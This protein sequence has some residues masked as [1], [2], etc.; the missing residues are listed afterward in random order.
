MKNE[1]ARC[2]ENNST[3]LI[4]YH[5]V[6]AQSFSRHQYK[7]Y[8]FNSCRQIVMAASS[9]PKLQDIL[10]EIDFREVAATQEQ[11]LCMVNSVIDHFESVA[12]IARRYHFS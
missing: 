2:H 11:K 8:S 7:E 1:R 3:A 6:T 12:L 10:G 9:S 5:Q 4:T